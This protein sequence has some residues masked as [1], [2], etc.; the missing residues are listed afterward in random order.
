VKD[1]FYFIGTLRLWM[2]PQLP[3]LPPGQKKHCS[4]YGGGFLLSIEPSL[5][6]SLHERKTFLLTLSLPPRNPHLNYSFPGV[7]KELF[8]TEN[9]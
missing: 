9:K 8:Q 2:L 1:A 3:A 4:F 5:L 7:T 6:A